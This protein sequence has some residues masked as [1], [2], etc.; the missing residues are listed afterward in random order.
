MNISAKLI[1]VMILVV[2][3]LNG[4]TLKPLKSGP[5]PTIIPESSQTQLPMST[6]NPTRTIS[7]TSTRIPTQ[8]LSP[9]TQATNT[10]SPSPTKSPFPT[11]DYTV[12]Y[13]FQTKGLT[14]EQ[15]KYEMLSFFILIISQ[16]YEY[17]QIYEIPQNPDLSGFPNSERIFQPLVW[18]EFAMPAFCRYYP[19]AKLIHMDEKLWDNFH[20]S[21]DYTFTEAQTLVGVDCAT[22]DISMFP[23]P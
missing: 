5:V 20:K 11:L 1:L 6:A 4:C 7:P 23:P 15:I 22:V 17:F 8:T 14:D 21:F 18:Q 3:L 2:V 16:E 13:P 10:A 9:T 19:Y 12:E